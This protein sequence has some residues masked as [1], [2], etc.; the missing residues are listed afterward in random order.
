MLYLRSFTAADAVAILTWPK[1]ETEFYWW[2][3]GK[4]GNYPANP[5]AMQ[6]FYA[7]P[8]NRFCNI[9]MLFDSTGPCGHCTVRFI[10][11]THTALRLGFIILNPRCRGKGYGKKMLQLVLNAVRQQHPNLP[12]TLGV[13]ETNLPAIRCYQSAGFHFTGEK[14]EF[15][16]PHGNI[17]ECLMMQAV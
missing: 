17:L 5:T 6:R 15:V 11:D 3:A 8:A 12:I 4:F 16:S 10:D 9:Y 7:D 13:F 1:N 14:Q 2:S